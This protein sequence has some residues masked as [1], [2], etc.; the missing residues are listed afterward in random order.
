VSG[1]YGF[2]GV[3]FRETPLRKALRGLGCG[4]SPGY[5]GFCFN[6]WKFFTSG[7]PTAPDDTLFNVLAAGKNHKNPENPVKHDPT[8]C[9]TG[10][11]LPNRATASP[12][13]S[14]SIS[15]YFRRMNMSNQSSIITVDDLIQAVHE[16]LPNLERNT[17]YTL[18]ELV[19]NERWNAI[20]KGHRN[21]LGS[22]FKARALR[23]ELPVIWHD[24]G[25]DNVQKYQLK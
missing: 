5:S 3:S 24:R 21:N 4:Q 1:F 2:N 16:N 8:L 22:E 23:G 12:R 20:Y 15:P 25:T 14:Q 10:L 18:E 7:T 13:W 11:P 19:G 9:G 6:H 17:P